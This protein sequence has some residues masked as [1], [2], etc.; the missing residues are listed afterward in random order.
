MNAKLLFAA[1]LAVAL[2]SSYAVAGEAKPL[3][4]ADVIADYQ[5]AAASGT[6]RKNDY[7]FDK[8]DFSAPSTRTRA[9]V[10]AEYDAA[11]ADHRLIGPLRNRTYNPFGLEAL[12]PSTL[13]R[14]QV[15]ADVIAARQDGSLRRS[16]Y[17]DVPVT[18][19]RRAHRNGA[20]APVLAGTTSTRAGS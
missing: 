14:A 4:R 16:D 2:A 7:D 15:K 20:V 12:R 13:A 8:Y 19:A 6:L 9:E 17:E 1:T 11:R 3:T 10:V 18:V 5:Q